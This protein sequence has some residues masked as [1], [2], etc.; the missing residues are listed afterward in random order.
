MGPYRKSEN[1]EIEAIIESIRAEVGNCGVYVYDRGG[2]R[3]LTW[4]R[5]KLPEANPENRLVICSYLV[6]DAVILAKYKT[7][8]FP[9]AFS[10][11]A[12]IDF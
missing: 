5:Q 6:V 2:D 9:L 3:N 1:A 11:R 7:S 4:A 10:A 12:V 8:N